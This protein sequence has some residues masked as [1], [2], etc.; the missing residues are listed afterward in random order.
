MPTYPSD[1]ELTALTNYRGS[2]SGLVA[3]IRRL[4]SLG[5]D[6]VATV[7]GNDG[8][9]AFVEVRLATGGWSGNEDV[10][11]ALTGTCFAVTFWE[12]THR[13]GLHVYRVPAD[14]WDAPMLFDGTLSAMG[15]K[16][17]RDALIARITALCGPGGPARDTVAKAVTAVNQLVTVALPEP[18]LGHDP[19]HGIT[20]IWNDRSTAVIVRASWCGYSWSVSTP[21]RYAQGKGDMLPAASLVEWLRPLATDNAAS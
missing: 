10:I 3:E 21:D 11:A 18:E 20:L 17:S 15:G 13:G 12:A 19:V 2:P 1:D 5:G 7:D 6:T 16:G 9:P 14:L 4:W 8:E